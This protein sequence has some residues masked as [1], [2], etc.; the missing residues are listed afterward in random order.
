MIAAL[1]VTMIKAKQSMRKNRNRIE[2]NRMA[3][4]DKIIL[5]YI[6]LDYQYKVVD[7]LAAVSVEGRSTGEQHVGYDSHRPHVTAVVVTASEHFRGCV[8]RRPDHLQHNTLHCILS[9]MT[10]KMRNG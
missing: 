5:Y 2:L 7:F 1:I 6:I 8:V 3:G 10:G 9:M 4:T